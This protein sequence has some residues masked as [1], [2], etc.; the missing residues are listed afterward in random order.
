MSYDRTTGA[1]RPL[2]PAD[3]SGAR[4]WRRALLAAILVAL[5]IATPAC[6]DAT[7]SDLL[8]AQL[9]FPLLQTDAERAAWPITP[10]I[11]GGAGLVIRATALFGCGQPQ[12]VAVRAG[13]QVIVTARIVPGSDRNMCAAVVARW[14]PVKITIAHLPSGDYD[15]EARVIGHVGAA[16][17]QVR[18]DP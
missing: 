16:R 9:D 14:E 7:A 11:Q 8:A 5:A 12:A 6:R 3:A 15:V 4:I 18:V 10:S 2:A 1:P 13:S 17:F